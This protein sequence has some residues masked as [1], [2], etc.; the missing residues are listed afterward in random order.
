[1]TDLIHGSLTQKKKQSDLTVGGLME[2]AL[3]CCENVFTKSTGKYGGGLKF[4]LTAQQR[5]LEI[6]VCL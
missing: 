1:M 2:Y 3:Y 6:K 4:S 5:T